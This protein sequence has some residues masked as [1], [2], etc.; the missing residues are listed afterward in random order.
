RELRNILVADGLYEKEAQAMV[1][2][3]RDSWFEEGSRLIY[4]VPRD[5]V[6]RILPLDVT[7]APASVARV[8]VGR[9]ELVTPATLRAVG[10]AL[11]AG[12]R[13]GLERYG[14][15]LEPIAQRLGRTAFRSAEIVDTCR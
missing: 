12:D 9:I 5:I 3:W 7:P 2:T 11:D 1:D 10:D 13:D 4:V 6:D 8:F 14:R 15:F